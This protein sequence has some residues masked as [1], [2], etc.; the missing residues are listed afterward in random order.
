M[1]AAEMSKQKQ[2]IWAECEEKGLAYC[3]A[4][5]ELSFGTRRN[6]LLDWISIAE[7]QVKAREQA[8]SHALEMQHGA[9][10][11]HA[12]KKS[13]KRGMWLAISAVLLLAIIVVINLDLG[14]LLK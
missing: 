8:I 7:A 3:K 1:A 4:R 6:S 12:A 10:I 2:A 14:A 9:Q 13:A 5:A 11:A